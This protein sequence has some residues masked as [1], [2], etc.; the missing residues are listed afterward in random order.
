MCEIKRAERLSQALA[1]FVTARASLFTDRKIQVYQ[2]E[3]SIDISQQ[4]VSKLWTI[5]S[6]TD[7]YFFKLVFISAWCCDF[8]QLFRCFVRQLTISFHALLCL[9]FHVV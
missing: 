9:T 6:P 8:V 1:H 7:F 3:T 2:Y 4:F 5:N